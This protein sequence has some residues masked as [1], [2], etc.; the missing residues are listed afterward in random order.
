M[1]QPSKPLI[2]LFVSLVLLD[3]VLIG[4]IL[5]HGKVNFVEVFNHIK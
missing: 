4:A 3:L 1:T 2:F 5:V